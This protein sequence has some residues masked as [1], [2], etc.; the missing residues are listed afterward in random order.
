MPAAAVVAGISAVATVGSTVVGAI[1]AKKQRK[2]TREATRL[3]R[4]IANNKAQRER[5]NT[6][7]QARLA[8]GALEQTGANSGAQL[9]SIA[10]GSL[11]SI[12]SQLNSNLSF[13]D[14][15]QSLSA[16]SAES[17][18][19]AVRHAGNVELAG[20]VGG[21]SSQIFSAAGGTGAFGKKP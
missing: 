19:K 1:E 4:Q 21:I 15:N 18:D 8:R 14:T 17:T 6:I 13:L 3:Q 5:I 16:L 2:A 9:S 7:R 11:G 10:L 12:Q 20:A